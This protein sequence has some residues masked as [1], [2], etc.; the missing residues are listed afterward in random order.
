MK[1]R[2]TFMKKNIFLFKFVVRVILFSLV[3]GACHQEQNLSPEQ[4]LEL[5][6]DPVRCCSEVEGLLGRPSPS[7][8]PIKLGTNHKQLFLDNYVLARLENVESKLHQPKKYGAVIRPDQ[9]WEGGKVEIRGGGPFWSQEEKVWKMWYFARD[10]NLAGYAVSEDGLRWE[11]PILNQ[12]TIGGSTHNNAVAVDPSLSAPDNAILNIWYHPEDPDPQQRYKGFLGDDN[13][14]PMVSANGLDWRVLEVAEIPS[15]DESHL[16][17]DARRRL[18]VATL[19]HSGPYGRSHYLSVSK[20]FEDWTDPRDCLIFHADQRDQELGTRRIQMHLQSQDLRKPLVNHPGEYQTEIYA[21]PVFLYEGIYIGMPTV[22]NQSAQSY[23]NRRVSDGVS[24]VELA[25][26]RDLIHWER[27]GNR[28]KFIPLSP[29]EGGKNYDTGQL[30]AG[31]HPVVQND[32]LWFY[33]SGLR[34]RAYRSYVEGRGQPPPDRGA[35]CLAKLR[36]DGFVS[37]DAGEKEGV[38]LTKP[39][40]IEGKT[41]HVNL[42]APQ[43]EVQAEIL[44][45]DGK[46]ALAGF[47][48][49]E[50]IPA[51]GD[52]LDA[53]LKWSSQKDLSSLAG[54]I[55]RIRFA[56]RRASLY[57]FWVK[58]S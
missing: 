42:D 4:D 29:L 8:D 7:P 24:M 53:E 58:N 15:Q 33:Y 43:G 12:V 54:K 1:K 18:F 40:V 30:L 16:F 57:A 45:E 56:L 21:L 28:E 32:E 3:S 6:S 23:K 49:E 19:K 10:D 36:L 52:S 51:R 22:L 14:K 31:H 46:E 27:V 37:L 47:S 5:F 11:K 38:V 35:I 9:P 50:S 44:E 2:G 17:Y 41:L 20:D 48:L 26:S 55:V 13:R 39:M 34:W 25:V